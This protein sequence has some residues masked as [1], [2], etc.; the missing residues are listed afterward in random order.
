MSV[1]TMLAKPDNTN[2]IE[3]ENRCGRILTVGS[4]PTLSAKA[5]MNYI[6]LGNN[7]GH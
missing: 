7:V 1:D 4:N 5:S 6:C 3:L 2:S